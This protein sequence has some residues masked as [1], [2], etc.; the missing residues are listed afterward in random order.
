MELVEFTNKEELLSSTFWSVFR[1]VM[2]SNHIFEFKIVQPIK[3]YFIPEKSPVNNHHVWNLKT[4]IRPNV[5]D[6][7]F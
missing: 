5:L 2:Y 1:L 6:F 3:N 4:D 7:F